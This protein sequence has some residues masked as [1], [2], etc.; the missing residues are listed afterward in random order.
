MFSLKS[1]KIFFVLFPF[2][3][4]ATTYFESTFFAD[5]V[6]HPVKRQL[7]TSNKAAHFL[8]FIIY[9]LLV[10]LKSILFFPTYFNIMGK[11][12]RSNIFIT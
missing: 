4:D 12:T 3:K 8:N 1:A 2:S 11:N 10:D 9:L 7:L 5:E 6:V